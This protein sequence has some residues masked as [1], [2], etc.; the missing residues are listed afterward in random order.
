VCGRYI[1]ENKRLSVIARLIS[2][3]SW[4]GRGI[5]QYRDGGHGFENVLT[6]E[7]FQLLDYLPRAHFLGEIIKNLCTPNS[8]VISTLY[9]EIEA[10]EF[11]LLPGN[12]Y[13]REVVDSHQTGMA[14]QPDG[15]LESKS[16]YAILEAKRIKRSAF[17]PGQ[18]AKEF[19]LV[20]RESKDKIPLLVFVL[21]SKPPVLVNGQ[22][23]SEIHEE[24]IHNLDKVHSEA[25]NHWRTVEEIKQ[26]AYSHY[27]WTTW[28]EIYWIVK[29]QLESFRS[30][31]DSV[32]MCITRLANEV[33]DAIE[34]HS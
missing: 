28:N 21:G 25:G 3:L 27:A 20:T 9:A 14:V 34:R 5:N 31:N 4:S 22:G 26:L 6:A 18:I 17:Q 11:T 15:I 13:L 29:R 2:E 16:M 30:C 32:D 1:V 10:A 7:V 8:Q 24:I 33:L 12:F 19:Y 23:R